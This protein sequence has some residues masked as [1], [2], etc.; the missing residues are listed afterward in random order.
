MTERG[1]LPTPLVGL[2]LV[3]ALTLLW[4]V[5][6]SLW[7]AWNDT[8]YNLQLLWEYA[9]V[10]VPEIVLTDLPRSVTD[11]DDGDDGT[12]SK[13]P[14]PPQQQQGSNSNRI[15]TIPEQIQCYDP[16]TGQYLGQV[17]A[18]N[19]AQVHALCVRAAAAQVTWRQTTFQQRRRV[20]RTLQ[21]Y[22]VTH[23]TTI[24]RVS[25]RDSGKPVVDACLGEV[26][27]TCE[28][29]R[30]L[31]ASGELWLRPERRTTGPMFLHKHAAVEY[32]PLGVVAT[33][34]PWNYPFHNYM[35]HIL[36]GIFAGNA[37]VGKVSEHTSWS[38]AVY[39][40]RI[41]RAAL[42]ING[43]DPDLV[44]T[45]TGFGEAG[46][47]LV[48][49][50]LVDKIVFTGS[51]AVGKQVMAAAAQHLKPVILELGGK[52]AMVLTEDCRL[53]EVIPWTMRGCFQNSGQNC[54]GIERVM[55]YESLHDAFVQAVAVKVKALRQ[56]GPL[57][58]C[59]SDA[60]VDCGALVMEA[61]IHHIQALIDDAVKKG[62]TLLVGGKR[63]AA[64]PRG[65]FYEPTLLTGVQ[66]GMRIF[67]EEVFGP[68]MAVVQVPHDSDAACVQLVNQSDFGLGSSVYCRDAARGLALARQLRT[69]MCCVND[70]GSHYLV[71]SLP[72]GGTKQ[73]GFG[74]FAGI[75][76]LRA[77][78]LERSILTDRIPGIKTSI[79]AAIDYPIDK[80]KGLP[81]ADALV[82]LFY[83]ES[84]M[85]KIK[86]I[87][88]LIKY[89]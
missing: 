54:V 25:G 41:V 20:L 76:G 81:F 21:R 36:S 50:P 44:Q 9:F 28:K 40:S 30:T 27:T 48:T 79:P 69:G 31:C 87:V 70:F 58:I 15:D 26:L 78:C 8:F 10:S 34:A 33:I 88:G 86:G 71:Q 63:N 13:D 3:C 7:T 85:Q 14:P 51:T 89:G 49:D 66:P 62:A 83:N 24:C 84:W 53:A 64:L 65:Q 11:D 37:V 4:I 45:V 75:E 77:M 39:Y 47:A 72:F 42:T 29:I 52:D 56:G 18:M 6:T 80:N 38:A 46:A 57:A 35:N 55:V 2:A 16:S 43:H 67:H 23:V 32:V 5:F 60:N 17:P 1:R 74:R 82:Q 73:S 22:I 59:G 61:Q 12:A 68:V 19:A